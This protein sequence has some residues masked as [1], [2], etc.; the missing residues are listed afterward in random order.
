[1][2]ASI[3]DETVQRCDSHWLT[4]SLTCELTTG[5]LL[6]LLSFVPTRCQRSRP[7]NYE[8]SALEMHIS[9]EGSSHVV[10][11]CHSSI[12]KTAKTSRSI[13]GPTLSLALPWHA[14]SLSPTKHCEMSYL[15]KI[16]DN[17]TPKAC[18]LSIPPALLSLERTSARKCL[19]TCSPTA[20]QPRGSWLSLPWSR[21]RYQC[22]LWVSETSGP[23]DF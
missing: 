16:H 13:P 3:L 20:R 14:F 22:D 15:L 10:L 18:N 6:R 21:S 8:H 19:I 12:D 2:L 9:R 7:C 23:P 17:P 5:D 4:H 1:M 11:I